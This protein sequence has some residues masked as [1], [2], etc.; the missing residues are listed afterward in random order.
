MSI[1]TSHAS[2]DENNNVYLIDGGEKKLIGQYPNVTAEEALAY[3][4]RKFHDLDAQ[5]KILEQRVKSTTA[6]PSAVEENLVAV[7]KELAEP[8]F[9]GD[10]ATLRD[11]IHQLK[12]ALEKLREDHKQKTE[13]AVAKA[14][15]E[16]EKIAAK[17]EQIAN[18]DTTKTIWKN[19]SKEMQELFEKWQALQK[20]GPRV[21]KAQAD[22]IWK[23]FSKA[24]AKFEADKRAFF[25]E[26]DKRVKEA[27]KVKTDIVKQAEALSSKGAEAADEFKKLQDQWKK[28][29]RIGK[30]EDALWEKFKAAGDVI[31]EQK[32]A[33]DQKLR[34]QEMENYKQKLELVE[35]AEKISLDDLKSA[36]EQLSKINGEWSKIG[37]VPRDKVRELDS[38]MSKI[39]TAVK[40]K[41]EDEWRRTDPESQHRSNS[42]IQQLEQSISDLETEIKSVTDSKKKQELE[43]NLEARKSWL[44]AARQAAD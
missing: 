15:A 36:R 24:R 39:E 21:P 4:E 29:A 25:A 42:L 37:R 16:K 18:R 44:E 30:G 17:A 41:E 13:E 8:K 35:K 40:K 5:I 38:R 11:R 23:R 28:L 2:V 20:S 6:T 9:V 26:L 22:P 43:K 19:A 32:K 31:F 10:I 27:K 14:L 1:E 12:P 34:E 33:E 3:F 7:E